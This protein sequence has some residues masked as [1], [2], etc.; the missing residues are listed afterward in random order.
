MR[1]KLLHLFNSF[2]VGGVER[3]HMML[4]HELAGDYDQA[5]WSYID[6][7]IREEL[8]AASIPHRIGRFDAAVEMIREGGYDCVVL[9]TNR[10]MREMAAFFNAHPMPV[11]Y[12]RSFLRWWEGNGTYFDAELERLSYSFPSHT[13][14]SGPSLLDAALSL[15]TD[16]PGAEVLY[17]GVRMDGFPQAPRTA[18]EGGPLRVGIL[19]NFSPQK[20]QHT[21]INVL[22]DGIMSGEFSLTLGGEALYPDYA[23]KVRNAARG[24]PVDFKGYVEDVPEFM[25]GIDALLLSSTHEG[26]PIVLMEGMAAGLP[27]VAPAIGDTAEL[28]GRGEYGILYEA[29]EFERIPELLKRLKGTETY[30]RYARASVLRSGEF[31]I[32]TTANKL[33]KAIE[34]VLV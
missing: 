4:V 19:A 20:N 9:R 13:F 29:E 31:N 30:E 12:I 22:R 3:Q 21:A 16:I 17:N 14:F 27:V 18:P 10:Y 26:W 15:D 32:A 23:E 34:S 11:V 1:P 8:D 24:V 28:L 25:A 5:C 6:G 2:E 33:R 7:P